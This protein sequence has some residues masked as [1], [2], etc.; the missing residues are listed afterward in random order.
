[1]QNKKRRFSFARQ[2][3]FTAFPKEMVIFSFFILSLAM[4]AMPLS[5]DNASAAATWQWGGYSTLNGGS[6]SSS[7]ACPSGSCSQGAQSQGCGSCAS[8]QLTY[9]AVC[10]CKPDCASQKANYCV[11]EFFDGGCGTQNCEGTGGSPSNPMARCTDTGAGGG[12]GGGSSSGGACGTATGTT[13]SC[14]DFPNCL[15]GKTVCSR[16][17][18]EPIYGTELIGTPSLGLYNAG[19]W[20]GWDWLCSGSEKCFACIPGYVPSNGTCV[21]QGSVPSPTA[22]TASCGSE[23]GRTIPS[24]GPDSSKLCIKNGAA[25]AASGFAARCSSGTWTGWTWN[26]DSTACSATRDQSTGAADANQRQCGGTTTPT[27]TAGSCGTVNGQ[28]FTSQPTSGLCASGTQSAVT[29]SPVC[30]SPGGPGGRCAHWTWTCGSA[31]CGAWDVSG[32]TTTT[33]TP[34]PLPTP[35]TGTIQIPG[36]C[37]NAATNYSNDQTQYSGSFCYTGIQEPLNPAF[38]PQNGS[39]QWVCKGLTGGADSNTCV[40]TR[41]NTPPQTCSTYTASTAIP[42]GYGSPFNQ[43]SGSGESLLSIACSTNGSTANAGSSQSNTYT[44]KTGFV[45]QNGTWS[46][47]DFSGNPDPSNA[48]WFKGIA[49][50]PLPAASSSQNFVVAFVCQYNGGKWKCGCR[51]NACSQNYWTLQAYRQ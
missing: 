20:V 37:G 43:L 33:P 19:V 50:A 21:P 4:A 49:T 41:N 15:G 2:K 44:Y 42:A 28:D 8:G 6:C 36:Y 38:P 17:T 40:A 12:G 23:N 10:A 31:T 35:G 26:C 27:P 30:A 9:V 46:K 34:T 45:S 48:G 47:I 32:T 11:G 16:G 13:L 3:C 5:G 24:A 25:Y 22:G 51:D 18:T 1:M 7:V 29:Y 14:T 39:S